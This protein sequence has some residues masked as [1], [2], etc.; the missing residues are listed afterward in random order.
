MMSKKLA[1]A[2]FLLVGLSLI[3]KPLHGQTEI[4]LGSSGQTA[5]FTG[6]SNS[7][8]VAMELGSCSGVTCTLSGI[9]YG[10]GLLLSEGKYNMTSP[11]DLT[12]EFTDPATGLI[13]QSN[14][15]VFS[16]GSS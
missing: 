13:A 9:A 7:G 14:S 3:P 15:M 10:S 11:G 1:V 8:S 2:G 6:T 16:Y 12:L 4:V 5:V